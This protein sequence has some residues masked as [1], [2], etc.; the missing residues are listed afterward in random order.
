MKFGLSRHALG[1]SPDR[2]VKAPSRG[3]GMIR[4]P[5]EIRFVVFVRSGRASCLARADLAG[6]VKFVENG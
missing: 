1:P 4:R 2:S 6:S 5:E 3:S